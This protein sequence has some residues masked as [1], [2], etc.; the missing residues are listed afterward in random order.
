MTSNEIN[1]PGKRT[2]VVL[3]W[4]GAVSFGVYVLQMFAYTVV[5][6]VLAINAGGR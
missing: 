3:H 6:W 5:R 1:V 4:L 2:S